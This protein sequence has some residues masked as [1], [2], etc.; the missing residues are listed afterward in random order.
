MSKIERTVAEKEINDWLER[1]KVFKSTIEAN[2]DSVKLLVDGIV[3]GVLVLDESGKFRHELL[4]PFGGESTAQIKE[5][6]Y[7]FRLNDRMLKPHT[8]GLSPKDAEGRLLAYIAALTEQNRVLLESMDSLDK[9]VATAIAV[10][11]L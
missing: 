6:V 4:H 10:F 7:H 9:K 11:F 1:K 2:E 3:E 5:L 8:N